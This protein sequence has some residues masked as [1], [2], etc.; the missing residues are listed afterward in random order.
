MIPQHIIRLRTSPGELVSFTMRELFSNTWPSHPT[1][2]SR[3]ALALS[4]VWFVLSMNWWFVNTLVLAQESE[5]QDLQN[6][7]SV[8]AENQFSRQPTLGFQQRF[9]DE[10]VV[11]GQM[12]RIGSPVKLWMDSG[13]FDAYRTDRRFAPF[14]QRKWKM[15]VEEMKKGKLDFAAEPQELSPDRYGLRFEQGADSEYSVDQ[16]EQIRGGGWELKLL[17]EK[18]DQFVLHFDVCGTSAQCFYILHDRRGLSVHFLLDVDG[19]IYQTLD[20]KERAWH[21]TKS[22]DRSIGIEIANIGAYPAND[23]KQTLR[24]WYKR[25]ASGQTHLIF[26]AYVRGQ[27]HLQTLQLVPRRNDPVMGTIDDLQ[28]QQ[29]DYT[30]SQYDALSKLSAALCDIFPNL[31]PEAPRNPDGIVVDRTLT[32]AQWLSF[33]GILGHHHV[34]ENKIDPGPAMDWEYLLSET[35]KQLQRIHATNPSRE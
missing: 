33:H 27:S 31:P 10:I 1:P 9:G 23:R 2:T 32:D 24:D 25:D 3:I 6:A 13:G 18:I 15:T 28:Y 30:Q 35:K 29:Y 20:L 5:K 8:S 12:Y 14:D 16:L 11:C 17:Q 34:Q 4:T 19:T 22:N 21:A 7:A 26:P